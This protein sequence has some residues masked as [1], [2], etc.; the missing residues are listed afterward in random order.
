MPTTYESEIRKE[1]ESNPK[2]KFIIW[3]TG[4]RDQASYICEY[5]KYLKNN[6]VLLPLSDSAIKNS[7]PVLGKKFLEY[8]FLDFPDIIITDRDT[9]DSYPII[10]IEILEQKPVG[11]NHTQRFAR[12]AAS[13][14]KNTPFAYLTPQQRYLFDKDKSRKGPYKIGTD[15]YK[16]ALRNEYQL[17]FSLYKLTTIHNIPCLPFFWPIDD[18][19][20]FISEGL[21]YND[22]HELRW[23]QLPPGPRNRNGEVYSEVQDFF[24]FIDLCIEY[25]V[26][27]KDVHNLMNEV[28]V[29]KRLKKIDP[30]STALYT[31]QHI[32][33][34]IPDGGNVKI[35]RRESTPNFIAS[36]KKH[37]NLRLSN[38][39]H[40]NKLLESGIFTSIMARDETIIVE[41]DSDPTKGNRGFSD[42]YSGVIASF[43]YRYCREKRHSISLDE[44]DANLIFLCLHTR[45]TR[46]FENILSNQFD[47]DMLDK[48]FPTIKVKWSLRREVADTIDIT[49]RLR[50]ANQT[51]LKKE[52]KNLFYFCDVIIFADTLFVGYIHT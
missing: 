19:L 35:A 37:S 48:H 27:H 31:K 32:T 12:A 20:K 43:D 49:R 11:W 1:I 50:A 42:P 13:A 17:P 2:E 8:F 10:G 51:G 9:N 28:A 45:A 26:T 36:L 5:S 22:S 24:E 30:Q 29:K 3:Y 33:L 44:R 47:D 46:F 21:I 38:M 14:I 40:F 18:N 41:V 16:E 39:L 7:S 6:S 4:S 25:R 15:W 34:K 52:I 23:R